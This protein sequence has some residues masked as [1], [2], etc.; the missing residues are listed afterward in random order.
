M[1]LF[2]DSKG[3]PI[4]YQLFRGNQTD[5]VTYLPAI[6]QVKKQF[7]IERIVVVADKGMNSMKNISGTLAKGDGW[8]FSQKHRGLR[9]ASKEIQA[10]I[11]DGEG[12]QVNGTGTFAHKSMLHERKLEGGGTVT[13]KVLVT[14]NKAYDAREKARRAQALAYADKLTNA[15]LFRQT[16]KRGGKKYLELKLIDRETGEVKPFKPHIQLDED[17]ILF[18]SQFDGINVLVTSETEMSDEAMIEAYGELYK[19]EDCFRVTKTEF[20]ARPVYVWT[21]A[22]IKAHFL[23]CFVA[24]T[25][26]RILQNATNWGMSAGRLV[27]SLQSARSIEL[28]KVY[29]LVEGNADFQALNRLLKINWQKQIVTQKQLKTYAK[30]WCK[31]FFEQ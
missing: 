18:D 9:G 19:I 14:W 26:L 7:G 20:D 10:Y 24:L 13:E 27:G 8:L 6:E 16:A 21:E 2:M 5:P 17:R 23:T 15:E 1:G 12:W 3:I 31:T 29:S 11:L 4:S 28:T 22:H 25:L 30:D